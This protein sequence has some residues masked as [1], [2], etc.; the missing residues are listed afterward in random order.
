[1]SAVDTAMNF[2]CAIN[3]L[4]LILLLQAILKDRNRL[5][6]FSM[7][8]SFL[9]FVSMCGFEVAYYLMNNMVSFILSL[10]AVIFWL[11][12]FIYTLKQKFSNAKL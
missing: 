8:G 11:L 2:A 12:A 7:Y 5:K 9:T 3:F 1:M 10:S 4:A 6:G